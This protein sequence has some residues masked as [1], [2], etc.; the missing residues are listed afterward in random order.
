MTLFDF[1]FYLNFV[2]I[3]FLLFDMLS[4]NH[5]TKGKVILV[6]LLSAIWWNFGYACVSR[7]LELKVVLGEWNSLLFQIPML[8]ALVASYIIMRRDIDRDC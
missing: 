2:L 4:T 1:G 6:L 7:L 3:S 8:I 5:W